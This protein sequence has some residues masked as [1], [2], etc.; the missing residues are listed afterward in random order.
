MKCR[1]IHPKSRTA[2]DVLKASVQ[3]ICNEIDEY[4]LSVLGELDFDK[5]YKEQNVAW[6]VRLGNE[7]DQFVG[8]SLGQINKAKEL[9]LPY[10]T[11]RV[12]SMEL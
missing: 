12:I 8:L 1:H 4:F 9:L 3:N 5:T 11:I 2:P 6:D 7:D 10:N